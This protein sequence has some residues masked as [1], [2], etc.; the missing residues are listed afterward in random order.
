ML[1]LKGL[2]TWPPAYGLTTHHSQSFLKN[3]L[4]CGLCAVHLNRRG[5]SLGGAALLAPWPPLEQGERC[6]QMH[7]CLGQQNPVLSEVGLL[8]L[9]LEG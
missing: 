1:K 3:K 6:W 4:H 5:C 2:I 8:K 9:A 7:P